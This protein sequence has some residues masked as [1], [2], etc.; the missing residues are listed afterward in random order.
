MVDRGAGGIGSVGCR[1][2]R[3]LCP[4]IQ[5]ERNIVR[6][7]SSHRFMWCNTTQHN[8]TQHNTT[9]HNTTQHNTTQHNTTQ[10][11]TTQHNTT[12][13]NTTHTTDADDGDDTLLFLS[14]QTETH[15]SNSFLQAQADLIQSGITHEQETP[16]HGM[17]RSGLRPMNKFLVRT[18]SSNSQ[19]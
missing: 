15:H 1:R 13:H 3:R 6:A 8:T 10:H 18:K 9:Q 14:Q 7:G 2:E 5:H 16:V 11:N 19:H 4:W 12:Q 17:R